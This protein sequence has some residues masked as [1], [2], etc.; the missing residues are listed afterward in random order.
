MDLLAIAL[1]LTAAVI[2]ACWSLLSKRLSRY[3]PAAFVWLASLGSL[4][5]YGPI[6]LVL[7][8][9]AALHP[10]GTQ[11]VFMAGSILINLGYFML[12]QYGYRNGDLSF[13]YPIA[14]GTGPILA[15][16]GGVVLLGQVP[17]ALGVVG[18][19]AVAAGVMTLGLL[20]RPGTSG[21][22]PAP[23]SGLAYALLSGVAIAA[24]TLWDQHAV[25]A[26]AISPLLLNVVD[27]AGRVVLLAPVAV[28]N[29]HEVRRLWRECR[30]LIVA[31]GTLMPV[32]YLLFLY[33]LRLAPASVVSPVREV[34]VV[35]VVLAGGRLLA[36][37][38]LRVKL[39]VSAT[40]LLGLVTLTV[41]A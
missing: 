9:S 5:A 40:V 10:T 27:D 20:G 17:S 23:A 35:L 6:V 4:L 22:R 29:R 13:V 8:G 39:L 33:A 36:E 25:G 31:A 3:D 34:S 21:D 15:T 26:L 2:H 37:G 11:V 28:R 14:R 12:T 18:L 19:L 30:W 41:G 7:T 1:A 32:P 24:Y 16:L 38:Q